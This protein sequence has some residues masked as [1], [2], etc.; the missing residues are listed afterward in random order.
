MT[1]QHNMPSSAMQNQ[2]N[3]HQQF[4]EEDLN[5]RQ[6]IMSIPYKS[7]Q[8][9]QSYNTQ[10]SFPTLNQTVGLPELPRP[11]MNYSQNTAEYARLHMQQEHLRQQ[12][13]QQFIKDQ[14]E[15]LLREQDHLKELI[16]HQKQQW[17]QLQHQ[18]QA[19]LNTATYSH[20]NRPLIPEFSL[21]DLRN[22]NLLRHQN[23]ISAQYNSHISNEQRYAPNVHSNGHLFAQTEASRKIAEQAH[24]CTFNCYTSP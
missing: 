8:M 17:Y 21:T 24:A 9:A 14:E 4:N 22:Q 2:S 3:Y 23:Q 7:D 5:Q 15:K 16:Q 20:A 11:Q 13:A 1:T 10:S 12:L 19:I 18:K 6:G